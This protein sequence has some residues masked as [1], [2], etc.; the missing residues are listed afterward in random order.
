MSGSA[1]LANFTASGT[2][3]TI[4]SNLTGAATLASFTASGNLGTAG[5]SDISGAVTL[6]NFT[7]AG[8]LGASNSAT[9]SGTITLDNFTA[10][11]NLSTVS[12]LS[13][14][15]TLAGFSASGSLGSAG[16]PAMPGFAFTEDLSVFFAEFATPATAAVGV[17]FNVIFDAQGLLGLSGLVES[18][19]PQAL[20]KTADVSLRN[21]QQGSTLT[22][23]SIPYSVTLV[24]PDGTG[25]T[26]LQ[27]RRA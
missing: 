19:G 14:T 18:T 12:S 21:L 22:I 6:A 1:T 8:S 2:L 9:L 25:A 27:L 24:D 15:A 7:A 17:D 10:S 20:C 4:P 16:N 11:G 13:G 23:Q 26:L 3:G 5:N